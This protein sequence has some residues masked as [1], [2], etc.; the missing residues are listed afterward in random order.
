MVILTST[1]THFAV[2]VWGSNTGNKR[3]YI[4]DPSDNY[5]SYYLQW[6]WPGFEARVIQ[7]STGI[8]G[9]SICTAAT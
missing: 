9:Y 7:C 3:S 4:V 8:L 5:C 2:H 1:Y 6:V